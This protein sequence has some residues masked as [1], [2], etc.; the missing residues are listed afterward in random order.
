MS[1]LCAPVMLRFEYMST[2]GGW[3]WGG[4]YKSKPAPGKHRLLCLQKASLCFFVGPRDRRRVLQTKPL[5]GF[6]TTVRAP[7]FAIATT[8]DI[9]LLFFFIWDVSFFHLDLT[10]LRQ[11]FRSCSLGPFL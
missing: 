5:P 7:E 1:I 9:Q 10:F 6:P 2:S 11:R 8:D 3:G 4:G